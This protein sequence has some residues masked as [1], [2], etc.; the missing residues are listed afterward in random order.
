MNGTHHSIDYIGFSVT[1]MTTAKAFYNAVFGWQFTDY[2]E[3]YAGIQGDGREVGGFAKADSVVKGGPLVV[4]YSDNLEA[5]FDAVK[6]EG[7]KIESETFS[8]P[9]GR[10]FHFSDPSGNVLAVWTQE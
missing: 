8:F 3:G 9:G 6:N 5:T 4:I 7:G 10:R 2:G 1:D